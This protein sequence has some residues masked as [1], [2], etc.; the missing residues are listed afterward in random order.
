MIEEP[1]I[2]IDMLG[3]CSSIISF[4]RITSRSDIVLE[5]LRVALR[6]WK[7]SVDQN[8]RGF[9]IFHAAI[10]AAFKSPQTKKLNLFTT[11]FIYI[12]I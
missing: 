9:Y 11:S 4:P 10:I 6:I 5:I 12:F 3:I 1:V 8:S 7:Y 2:S